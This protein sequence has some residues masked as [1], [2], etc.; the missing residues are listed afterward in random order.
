MRITYLLLAT[1]TVSELLGSAFVVNGLAGREKGIPIFKT[2]IFVLVTVLYI[3]V[4]PDTLTTGSYVLFLL[5]IKW[6]YHESFK[7]SFVMFVL[8]IILV[9]LAE[10]I[11]YFPF[12]FVMHGWLSDIVN[13]FLAALCSAVVCF[14]MAKWLPL[15]HLKNWCKKREVT[16][17]AVVLFSLILMFTAIIDLRMTMQL[18]LGDYVYITACV[19][20]MLLLAVR[21]MRYRYEE[22]IRKKYFDAFCRV[23][24]QMKRRQH[25]FR[26]HMDAIYSLHALY[27][28]YDELV[29]EQRRYLGKLVDYEMPTDVLILEN[30]III[31]HI[32]EKITEAQDVG[33]RIH[34]KLS[35]S[36]ANCG[37]DDIHM[38]EILGTLLD[39]AIQDMIATGQKEFL[40]IRIKYEDG[41]IVEI[42]NPHEEMS[43]Q[44]INRM[45]EKGYSTKGEDRGIGL[46]HVRKLFQKYGIDLKVE[47]RILEE[48]NYISF[49]FLMKESTP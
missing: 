11:S 26:N 13:N 32:Y 34:M 45:F 8:C 25:K 35:C 43:S 31:A 42:A 21:L 29:E 2:F 19:V 6:S 38:V 4:T 20:L 10:L 23:I 22:K 16:Y 49:S 12:A 27:N 48:R 24:D 40:F 5:Y 1:S 46:Y 30:P 41:I 44:Q 7:N 37:I 39:N 3:L 9:G 14:V 15:E 18:D 33:L 17:I 36:L 47:N 28:D